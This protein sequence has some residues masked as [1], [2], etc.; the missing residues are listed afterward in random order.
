MNRLEFISLLTVN[1]PRI[2]SFIFC[3]VPNQVDSEDIMQEATALM[4]EKFDQ[5]EPGTNFLAW[6]LTI[7]RFKILSY[8]RDKS[9]N[10]IIFNDR[11]MKLLEKASCEKQSNNIHYI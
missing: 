7:A 3:R 4:W 11:V 8:R 2:K 1:Y 6:A 10:P 9:R 5:F